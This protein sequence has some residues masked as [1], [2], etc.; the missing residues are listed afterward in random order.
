MAQKVRVKDI[1]DLA[2]V[3]PGTVDRVLHN[4]GN[5]SPRAKQA[6]EGALAQLGYRPNIHVSGLSLKRR[7]RIV[8]TMPEV[9]SGEYWEATKNGIDR[10]TKEFDSLNMEC[11]FMY[12]NQFDLYSCR[13]T[14]DA[15]LDL[16]PDAV[17]IGPTFKDE[18]IHL[19]NHLEDLRIPYAYVDSMVEGTSPV[20]CFASNPFK[21]GYLI[22]KLLTSITPADSEYA[23]FQAVRIGDA[24]AN[25]TILRKAGFMTYL[26]EHG[27]AERVHRAPFSVTEPGRNAELVSGFFSKHPQVRG[28]TVLSSRGSIIADYMRRHDVQGVR[29]VCVDAT[30]SNVEAVQSGEIDFLIGQRPEQQGFLALK[31]LIRYLIY[32]TA[33]PV[34]NPMPIDIITRENIDLYQEFNELSDLQSGY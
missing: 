6:V 11:K 1:A 33:G 14:F 20:A 9:V 34:D 3:S 29:M 30:R 2:G 21:C 17:V 22:S 19:A 7:Y 4:R 27:L 10:A 28:A 25:T 8:V 26:Q 13:T 18:T 16:R 5:I 31:A 23:L 32:N 12:Y 24:S 15:I